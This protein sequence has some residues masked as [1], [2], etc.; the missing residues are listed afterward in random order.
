MKTRRM[1]TYL[2]RATLVM[3]ALVLT[4]CATTAGKIAHDHTNTEALPHGKEK[5]VSAMPLGGEPSKDAKAPGKKV[6][7]KMTPEERRKLVEFY[8]ELIAVS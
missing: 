8:K 4:G 7:K 2:T 5:E 6:R 3:A 1:K